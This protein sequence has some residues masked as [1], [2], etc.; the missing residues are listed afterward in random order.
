MTQIVFL[1]NAGGRTATYTQLGPT[2]GFVI[3]DEISFHVDPGPGALFLAY[4]YDLDPRT[5]DGVIVSHCHPDHYNDAEILMEAITEGCKTKKGFLVGP[6]S[7]V[8]G[9]EDFDCPI[10]NEQWSIQEANAPD[11]RLGDRYHTWQKPTELAE[12]FIRHTTKE[13]DFVID[14]FCCTGTFLISASKLNRKSKG[15]DI[16][17]DNLQIA[18]DRGCIYGG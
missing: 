14:P 10:S 2:G 18:I 13:G 4:K 7:V 8:C 1:G 9:N 5:F 11:G 16:S 17:K 12:R 15:C 3:Q 6:K